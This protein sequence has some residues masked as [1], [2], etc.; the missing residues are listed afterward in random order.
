[1]I[2]L[3][4]FSKRVQRLFCAITTQLVLK[5]ACSREP[6]PWPEPEW[7]GKIR[8]C[9]STKGRPQ[10]LSLSVQTRTGILRS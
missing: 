6:A 7:L 5:T 4:Y 3:E 10:V 2:S 1:M 9:G 8:F